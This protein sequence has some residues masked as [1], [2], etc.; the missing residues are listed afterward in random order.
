MKCNSCETTAKNFGTNGGHRSGSSGELQH[1]IFSLSVSTLMD[2]NDNSLCILVSLACDIFT[3]YTTL[4]FVLSI[5]TQLSLKY[6]GFCSAFFN[7]LHTLEPKQHY[8]AP[9][10]PLAS[11]TVTTGRDRGE[12][13]GCRVF[14]G[15]AEVNIKAALFTLSLHL[16][17]DLFELCSHVSSSQPPA[18]TCPW[19]VMDWAPTDPHSTGLM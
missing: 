11:L 17:L 2:K 10:S 9:V 3:Q 5:S 14:P 15:S 6:M 19:G 8:A 16:L 7:T 13:G 1:V 18:T 12:H 4:H